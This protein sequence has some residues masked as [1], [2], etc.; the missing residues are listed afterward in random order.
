MRVKERAGTRKNPAKNLCFFY[1]AILQVI[2]YFPRRLNSTDRTSISSWSN[3]IALIT[4]NHVCKPITLDL[5]G[6]VHIQVNMQDAVKLQLIA[7]GNERM[8]ICQ[9]KFRPPIQPPRGQD[10]SS[11]LLDCLLPRAG[12]PV[13]SIETARRLQVK[14][15]EMPFLAKYSTL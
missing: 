15:S 2:S 9:D 6:L 12:R 4:W 7:M 10:W 3:G 14:G 11:W 8:I 5:C 1:S 13:E